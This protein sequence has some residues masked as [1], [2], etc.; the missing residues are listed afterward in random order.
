MSDNTQR[1]PDVPSARTAEQLAPFVAWL[2]SRVERE[3]TRR[4]CREIAE[5]YLLFAAQDGGAIDT[6]RSRFLHDYRGVAPG[7]ARIGLDLFDEHQSI[8]R[9]TLP[10]EG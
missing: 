6:R 1:W 10:I 4:M 3:D 9:R 5:S 7:V 8:V 2:A